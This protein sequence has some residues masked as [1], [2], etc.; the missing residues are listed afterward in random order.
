MLPAPTQG[1]R[2]LLAVGGLTLLVLGL[3]VGAVLI[4]ASRQVNPGGDP[5]ERVD[6]LVVPTGSST[7]SIAT[8][9]AE[10]GVV[11]NARMFRYYVGWQGE[12]PWDAG[13]YVDF[14]LDSSFDEAIEV[15]DAGPVP[16]AAS[17]VRIV[18]GRTV[19]EALEEV[20]AQMPNL[21]VEALRQALDSGQVTSDYKP[22][23]VTSWEGLLFPDS[24]QFSDDATAVEV[25]QTMAT[26][27]EDVLDS[28]DYDRADALQGRS[29]YDL[30][31][32]ASL[33]ERE[34][35]APPEERG[36]I[37]RVISNR[38][39]A[40]EPLGID[41]TILYG[42]GRT[43][44]ELTQSDLETETPYNSRLVAGLP[45]TPIAL[46][47]E[48]SLA[49]AIAPTEGDW[50]WYVLTSNDP[51]SHLFTD[52]YDEFLDAKD[53]AQDRGVF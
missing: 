32:I 12:G 15:L 45:P 17:V 23:E 22:P 11:S 18:E 38:L 48:A 33:I 3:V 25:L 9:L 37:S 53:D 26:K 44:G 19:G 7:D 28:L 20:A 36:M 6:E 21:T 24:Y 41:A 30:I 35:G 52:D 29:A 4:W 47:G 16:D 40:G 13:T 50:R 42:L 27:M 43:S 1:G 34:T 8:L 10:E 14:R 5:G 2:R 46:P 51:P 31:T 49:A 39:D